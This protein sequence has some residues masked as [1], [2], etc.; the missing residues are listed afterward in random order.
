M[1]QLL[2]WQKHDRFS[3]SQ[4]L[5]GWRVLPC[6]PDPRRHGRTIRL[7]GMRCRARSVCSSWSASLV[8]G[9]A[10]EPSRLRSGDGGRM[11]RSAHGVGA[12]CGGRL[13]P[14]YLPRGS[15]CGVAIHSHRPRQAL[16]WAGCF[17]VLQRSGLGLCR[18]LAP[19]WSNVA[20]R[21]SF[22]P[23]RIPRAR[24]NGPSATRTLV[25]RRAC[26]PYESLRSYRYCP[27]TPRQGT[28]G[29]T[30]RTALAE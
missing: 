17:C 2:R 24:N 27:A 1:A 10:R 15:P 28:G 18:L 16:A 13:L 30:A 26:T 21:F 4:I 20:S 22:F 3:G 9:K 7:L 11:C 14:H 23:V 12:V 6:A 25:Q 8:C 19:R 5:T 29:S